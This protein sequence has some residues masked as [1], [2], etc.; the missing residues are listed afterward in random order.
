M[1]LHISQSFATL[2]GD[3]IMYIVH[4]RPAYNIAG[5]HEALQYLSATLRSNGAAPLSGRHEFFQVFD[6]FRRQADRHP[7][8][9]SSWIGSRGTTGE[10]EG[11]EH[12]GPFSNDWGS[13]RY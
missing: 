7:M 10:G 4:T 9:P 13:Y 6:L 3:Y 11:G 12:S 1:P 2:I 8:L 5:F